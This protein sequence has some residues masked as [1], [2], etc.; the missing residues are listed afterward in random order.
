MKT[1]LAAIKREVTR[2]TLV[3]HQGLNVRIVELLA[4]LGV[5]SL[6]VENARCVRQKMNSRFWGFPGLHAELSDAATEIYRLSVPRDASQSVL[7][8]LIDGLELRIPGRGAVYAQDLLEISNL[9]PSEIKPEPVKSDSLLHD[10]SLITGIQTKSGSGENLFGVAL[11]LGVGVP[12]VS[13]GIGT[14]IRDRLGLLRITISPE[15]ELVFLMVPSHDADGLQRLLIEEGHLDRPGGGFLYQTPIQ[16]GM[17]DPLIRIGRQEHAA[18]IEQIIAAIDDLKKGTAWRKRFFGME[19][20]SEVNV[21]A[22]F[23]HREISFFCHDGEGDNYVHAAMQAG[24]EGATMSRVRAL[25]LQDDEDSR[26]VP[27]EHGILCVSAALEGTILQA[28]YEV[29]AKNSEQD[30]ILQSL[31][32][33]SVFSHKRS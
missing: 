2:V 16:A 19:S 23:S 28:L 12:V 14:G 31:A 4:S 32:A 10:L 22:S 17:V 9:Q 21:G 27:F 8:K 11:K 26:S 6:I 25:Y 24:A 18:S 33:S 20:T 1:D 15:K 30:W 3:A 7:E 13:L 5:D 29:A